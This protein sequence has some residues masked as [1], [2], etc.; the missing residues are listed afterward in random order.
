MSKSRQNLDAAG[1]GLLFG[2][3]LGFQG[4]FVGITGQKVG[5]D[6]RAAIAG[7][8]KVAHKVLK[9]DRVAV[10]SEMSQLLNCKI[11]KATLD[12]WAAESK[13]QWRLPLEYARA[14]CEVTQDWSIF[15]VVLYPTNKRLANREELAA[16]RLAEC[17]LKIDRL[18]TERK[19]MARS[20]QRFFIVPK[21]A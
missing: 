17:D 9:K 19:A 20:I 13:A 16:A 4:A 15:E 5:R 12:A 11:T 1:Q 3:L 21:T 8:L 10:A 18:K 14:F 7:A 6:L 2:D